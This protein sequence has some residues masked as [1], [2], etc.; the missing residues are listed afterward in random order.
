MPVWLMVIGGLF[1]VGLVVAFVI[2]EWRASHGTLTDR[3]GGYLDPTESHRAAV[4]ATRRMR[5]G[6]YDTGGSQPGPH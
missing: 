2:N 5:G 6:R 1:L 3:R 4:D